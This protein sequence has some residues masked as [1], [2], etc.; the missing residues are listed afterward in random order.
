MCLQLH[1]LHT[2]PPGECFATVARAPPPLRLPL[3][4]HAP[5]PPLDD[6]V[7]THG[8][9]AEQPQ[10]QSQEGSV[11]EHALLQ[12][13]QQQ[14][15]EWEQGELLQGADLLLPLLAATTSARVL[16]LD[17]RRPGAPLVSWP[18]GCA[19][20]LEPPPCYLG[21]CQLALPA[22]GP[23]SSAAAPPLQ[24]LR[25][26]EGH[27]WC[28]GESVGNLGSG[29]GGSG[30]G[31][32]SSM[33]DADQGT[34]CDCAHALV[35]W[36]NR[37]VGRVRCAELRLQPPTLQLALRPVAVKQEGG[38]V[39]E[40][41]AGLHICME[42]VGWGGGAGVGG[43]GAQGQSF[44]SDADRGA[45]MEGESCK[46]GR[47]RQP[48]HGWRPSCFGRV[49]VGGGGQPRELCGPKEL[50]RH[51]MCVVCVCVCCICAH[52]HGC[53]S[54]WVHECMRGTL[55]AW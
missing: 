5:P 29:G 13:W 53:T 20:D 15:E 14:A 54:V 50:A 42:G 17:L 39:R 44:C 1:L 26:P 35:V 40:P 3:L 41:R 48:G 45:Q 51:P 43:S 21:F 22:G 32:H 28:G 55:S 25:D 46:Q 12:H 27:A 33:A 7:L 19:G 36:G 11:G 23:T 6:A 16:V 37:A 24:G 47:E 52:T 9:E 18:H 10:K 34:G 4:P 8:P 38:G 49:H 30:R 31:M 2:L